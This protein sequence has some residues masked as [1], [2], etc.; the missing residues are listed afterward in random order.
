M[1]RPVARTVVVPVPRRHA[2]FEDIALLFVQRLVDRRERR[3]CRLHGGRL[4]CQQLL[5]MGRAI[6]DSW[7]RV[8]RRRS[9]HADG[10]DL[11]CPVDD[12]LAPFVPE[13]ALVRGEVKL[14]LEVGQTTGKPGGPLRA[15]VAV[16]MVAGPAV[17]LA[18]ALPLGCGAFVGRWL[19]ESSLRARG[20]GDCDQDGNDSKSH[21]YPPGCGSEIRG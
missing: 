6:D 2:P 3:L 5:Q 14:D 4:C 20:K 13:R 9:L 7:P 8:G 15:G 18:V 12:R 10:A 1:P 16:P 19:S 17:V 11:C 21:W